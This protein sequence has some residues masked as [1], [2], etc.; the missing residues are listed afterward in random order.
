LVGEDQHPLREIVGEGQQGEKLVETY[1]FSLNGEEQGVPSE[2]QELE[3][4]V[5]EEIE[6]A[7][8]VR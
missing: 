8:C 2:D 5:E 4:K 7:K 6:E 3:G 1:G